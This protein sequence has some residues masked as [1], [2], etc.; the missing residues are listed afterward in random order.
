MDCSIDDK[1]KNKSEIHQEIISYL[2]GDI[3]NGYEF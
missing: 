2:R 1:I 3:F